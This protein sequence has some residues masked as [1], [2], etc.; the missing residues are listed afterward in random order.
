MTETDSTDT[1]NMVR[2]GSRASRQGDRGSGI[3][4]ASEEE[5]ARCRGVRVLRETALMAAI[6]HV[7]VEASAPAQQY[8]CRGGVLAV[9]VGVM[10]A[11]VGLWLSRVGV[12]FMTVCRTSI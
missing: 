3:S 1:G 2:E 6:A 7:V 9:G 10:P 8:A 4:Q 5:A 12:R 11:G